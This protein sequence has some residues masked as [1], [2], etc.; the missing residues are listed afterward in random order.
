MRRRTIP[1][2]VLCMMMRY[3][4]DRPG[5]MTIGGVH[6]PP[7]NWLHWTISQHH[8]IRGERKNCDPQREVGTG[9]QV[10]FFP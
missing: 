8:V 10:G 1:L 3:F 2:A 5:H 6:D 7:I 4:P 9:R